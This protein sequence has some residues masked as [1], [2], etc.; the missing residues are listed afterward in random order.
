[1]TPSDSRVSGHDAEPPRL[2]FDSR[3]DALHFALQSVEDSDRW[4]S[5]K[6]GD[7]GDL[8]QRGN[9]ELVLRWRPARERSEHH[10]VFRAIPLGGE[11]KWPCDGDVVEHSTNRDY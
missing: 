10:L 3:D 9:V 2:R 1:M 8:Y 6:R 11:P 7:I 4:L 5:L